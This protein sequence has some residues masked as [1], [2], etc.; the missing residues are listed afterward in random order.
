M[1]I[2]GELVIKSVALLVVEYVV[3]GFVLTDLRATIVAAI[4][5]GVV[6]TFIRPVLQIV[7]LPISVLTLGIWAFVINVFLLWGVAKVV[8]GF[9]IAS[10]STAAIASIALALVNAFLHK[11]AKSKE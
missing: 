6:N 1:K 3:P 8:P 7:M 5:I 11:I 10:F 2:I 9:E 4:V